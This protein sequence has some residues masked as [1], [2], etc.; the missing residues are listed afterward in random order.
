LRKERDG[1]ICICKKREKV[2]DRIER[3][4]M[5]SLCL[6]VSDKERGERERGDVGK[7]SEEQKRGRTDRG[8]EIKKRERER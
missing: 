7:N 3:G 1:E 2:R 5:Q 8:G 4:S 6:K